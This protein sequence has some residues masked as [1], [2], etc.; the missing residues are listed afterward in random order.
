[1]NKQSIKNRIEKLKKVINYHR[2]LY[3]VLDKQEISDAAFD[4][5]KHELRS[6]EE[7]YPEFLTSDSPTQRVGGQ[8]LDKFEKVAHRIPMLSIEDIFYREEL[9]QWESYLKRLDSLINLE[10]FCELKIDGFAVALIYENGVLTRAVTRGNG[11]IGENVTQN[12]KTIQS[13]PLK[14]QVY[15][16]LFDKKLQRRLEKVIRSSRIEIRGEVYMDKNVFTRIN[17]LRAENGK[18]LYSNPRNLAAGSI[19]QLDPKLAGSRNLKF[20]AYDIPS[21]IA[22]DIGILTH[23]QKHEICSSL[24][25][26]A[27]KGKIYKNI[28]EVINFW[29]KAEKKRDNLSFQVDGIVVLVNNNDDFDK[30]GVVGK[31]PRGIRA[32]KFQSIQA[33]TKIKDIKVQIGRTGAITPVAIL[34][35]VKIGGTIISKATLHNEDEIN[36]LGVKIGDTVIIERAGDVIPAVFESLKKLRN[37]E[38][39]EFYFPK[40]CPACETRLIR[41]A[42]EIIWRCPNIDC[43]ARKRESLEHFISKKGFNIEGLGPKIIE[44]LIT[45]ELI[46]EP[47]D[48]FKLEEKDLVLLERFAEKSAKNL[49]EEI[50]KTKKIPLNRFIYALGIRHIGEETSIDLAK[51][52]GNISSLKSLG[53]EE[54]EMVPDIGPAAAKSIYDWF[55]DKQNIDFL[56]Q[57]KK[58]GVRVL[59]PLEIDGKLLNK[60]FVITGSLESMS[61]GSA[62]TRIRELGGEI[63]GSLSKNTDFLVVGKSPG[64]KLSKAKE[65]SIKIL[66]EKEF[67]K[68]L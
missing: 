15:K 55:R 43:P 52:F 26:K 34:D 4:S 27:E 68:L 37:G 18:K 60:S 35:P 33:T 17:Q 45:E 19:R 41:S 31:S 50:R 39:K 53:L 47:S 8:P 64:S 29:Q 6:L 63:R 28:D 65:L 54:L 2:Y 10:Y 66:T 51:R 23:S 3:H 9:E 49:I 11:K 20:S 67:L 7:D 42:K 5:L 62:E 46:T 25:F 24:G 58:V 48:L 30:L 56:E 13:I 44:Q 21:D 1:M 59:A 22:T 40:K 14:L 32:F 36:R 61:R 38:E 16:P 57:L 12:I